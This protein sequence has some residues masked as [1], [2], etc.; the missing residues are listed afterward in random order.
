MDKTQ[1]E[2]AIESPLLAFLKEEVPFRLRELLEI[3]EE[4][5]TPEAVDACVN[6]LYDHSD[7]MFRY[8]A[9]DGCLLTILRNMER[10]S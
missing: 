2:E 6:Y 8:D 5:I 1:L 9:I 4:R 10:E 7:L 3:P